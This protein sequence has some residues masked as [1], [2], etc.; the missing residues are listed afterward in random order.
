MYTR[1]VYFVINNVTV[2]FKMIFLVAYFT[3]VVGLIIKEFCVSKCF[4][5]YIRKGFQVWI[6]LGTNKNGKLTKYAGC[7]TPNKFYYNNILP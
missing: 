3:G 7:E 6:V 5:F 1:R 2:K 4:D